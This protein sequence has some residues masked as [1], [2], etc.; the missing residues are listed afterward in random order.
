MV[1]VI[2]AGCDN[3]CCSVT[4]EERYAHI[5]LYP[6]SVHFQAVQAGS[7]PDEQNAFLFN[8]GNACLGWKA[9][10]SE[11]WLGC[12]PDSGF[13]GSCG[14][15]DTLRL[16]VGS[17][18]LEKGTH[19]GHIYINSRDAD[20][21]PGVIAVTYS[22]VSLEDIFVI[23][24][25]WWTDEVDGDSSGCLESARLTWDAD[26]LDGSTRE[27]SAQVFYRAECTSQWIH[28]YTTSCWTITG[29][30]RGDA[31]FVTV[32]NLAH[33]EYEFSIVLYLCGGSDPVATRNHEDDEDLD[34]KCFESL[35]TYSIYDAWWTDERDTDGDGCRD[36]GKLAWDADVDKDITSSV[37]GHVY[38]R[39]VGETSWTYH[40]STACYD[41]TGKSRDDAYFISVEGLD[42]GRYE[43]IIDL[44]ECNG[45]GK[46]AER[47]WE[48][49]PD[50][51]DQCFDEFT[52]SPTG[53]RIRDAWWS[54]GIDSDGDGYFESR[55]LVLDPDADEGSSGSI[56][57]KVFY[58]VTGTE[59][60]I[61]YG[62]TECSSVEGA[63]LDDT[64]SIDING[65][66]PECYHFSILLYECWNLDDDISIYHFGMDDDLKNQCFEPGD[67]LKTGSLQTSADILLSRTKNRAGSLP[68]GRAKV[69]PYGGVKEADASS[70]EAHRVREGR[71]KP[72]PR[73]D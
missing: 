39:K 8:S 65:I 66:G 60:W 67:T 44:F 61:Y 33:S 42:P 73:V 64:C 16:S 36:G 37:Q 50:L 53:I 11:S 41:I 7:L 71:G 31:Y 63:V 22:V 43:F 9:S 55:T 25:A 24:D 69:N 49:D 57:S 23:K 46:A 59:L 10:S 29:E 20:N 54:S 3:E 38:Y 14:D 27:V 26:V 70:G 62:Q 56:V 4:P 58:L 48:D 18:D 30:E 1:P 40:R 35:I 34:K 68:E 21:D 52:P 45:H 51:A 13:T 47:S 72:L 6:D 5:E 17:T 2:V 28:Y 32:D 12:R 19:K 15:T